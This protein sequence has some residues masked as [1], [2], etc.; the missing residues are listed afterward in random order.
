MAEYTS[1]SI[2]VVIAK[3][4]RDNDNKI[5]GHY[6]G[7]MLEWIPEAIDQLETPFS[8]LKLHTPSCGKEG[9]LVTYNHV[10][11]LPVEAC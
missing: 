2:K 9:E 7:L 4:S 1:T 5:P 11:K 8:L 3:I 6:A 10:A